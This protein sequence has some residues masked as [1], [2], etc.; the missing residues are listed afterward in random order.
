MGQ[1]FWYALGRAISH[2]ATAI[3]IFLLFFFGIQFFG[4]E[5]IVAQ[6]I[7]I[8]AALAP[9]CYDY[10]GRDLL[11]R[12]LGVSNLLPAETYTVVVDG[13]TVSRSHTDFLND[14]DFIFI[15][16]ML[17]KHDRDTKVKF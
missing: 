3:G 8:L 5:K 16:N 6:S 10:V 13:K 9:G 4:G 15:N 2:A 11:G 14:S 17:I 12:E 7:G 1:Q